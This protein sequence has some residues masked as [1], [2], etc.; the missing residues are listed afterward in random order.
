[1]T[2]NDIRKIEAHLK[3]LFGSPTLNV[4]PRPRLK[5]SAEV[6][7][8]EEFIGVVTDD[9]DDPGSFNFNMGIIAEDL[10]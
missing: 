3:R 8:G 4:R 10:E 9:E 6:Y 1:M 2:E 7:V 5:D